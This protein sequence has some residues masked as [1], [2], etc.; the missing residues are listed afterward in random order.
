MLR[1]IKTFEV[2]VILKLF[3]GIRVPLN[4]TLFMKSAY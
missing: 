1:A 2:I 4:L 3:D